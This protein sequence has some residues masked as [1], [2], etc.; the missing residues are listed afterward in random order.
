MHT[1]DDKNV[2]V[3]K[4]NSSN[5]YSD[6]YTSFNDMNNEDN[7]KGKG[8]KK[9]EAVEDDYT[10]FYGSNEDEPEEN[11]G[12]TKN[13]IKFIIIAVLIIAIIVVLIIFVFGKKSTSDIVLTEENFVLQ[14]GETST[15]SYKLTNPEDDVKASF[16]SSDT[17][18]AIVNSDGEVI[19]I[20]EGSCD[21][22]I[23]YVINGKTREK[24]C[25]ITVS[26]SSD[27]SKDLSLNISFSNGKDN[28]WT[29]KD[30]TLTIDAKS[31]Y[32]IDKLQYAINC[33]A[34]DCNFQDVTDNKIV[35]STPG[36]TKVRVLVHDKN[37]RQQEKTVTVLLDKESPEIKLLLDDKNITSTK[38]VEVC[39]TCSD[40]LSGCK[41]NKICKKFTSTKTNQTIIV[42]DKA[43]NRKN[44]SSFN[45]TIKKNIGPCNLKLSSDGTVSST[46]PD[47][48]L[49]YGF[50]SSYSGTNQESKK[51]E[52][53]ATTPNV[54]VANYVTYYIKDSKGVKTSCS[55]IVVKECKCKDEKSTDPKCPVTCSY[56]TK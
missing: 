50:S 56:Y 12:N 35:V 30:V 23:T 22:T 10:S 16:T 7:K 17:N 49:Y 14:A 33:D 31:V 46:H 21:I 53:N 27:I 40:S 26:G 13:I 15:I 37:N 43:G 6:F 36:T 4:S 11:K 55:L 38:E 18:V 5:D 47:G 42:E 25:K 19:A 41:Q 28:S 1:N 34:G 52:I 51:I 54:P 8:K 32:G 48:A 45:V 9:K 39:A 44:S 20:G 2:K 3:K 29:N 24:K